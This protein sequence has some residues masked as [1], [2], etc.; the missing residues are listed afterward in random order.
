MDC[1]VE[2]RDEVIK[3]VSFDDLPG[4]TV[5][6]VLAALGSKR[7]AGKSEDDLTYM[8]VSE[9]RKRLHAKGL[10]VDGSR[11]A[12]GPCWRKI[13]TKHIHLQVVSFA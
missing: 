5:N 13:L 11:K 2:N 6:D 10:C 8:R 3:K 7:E 9:L 12:V 4:S 1:V